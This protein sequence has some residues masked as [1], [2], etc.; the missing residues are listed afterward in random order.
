[1]RRSIANALI[2]VDRELRGEVPKLIF[3]LRV[4]HQHRAR[5]EQ[6]EYGPLQGAWYCREGAYGLCY[7]GGA[8][9]ANAVRRGD[10]FFSAPPSLVAVDVFVFR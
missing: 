4:G 5:A 2:R 1:M 3:M 8:V 7:V 6:G 10:V 9:A